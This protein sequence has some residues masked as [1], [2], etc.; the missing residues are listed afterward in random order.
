M[1]EDEQAAVGGVAGEVD[2][3][4]DLIVADLIGEG[5]VVE[6]DCVLPMMREG[7]EAL[8]DCVGVESVGIAEGFDAI[9]IVMGEEVLDEVADGMGAEIGGDV[10]DAEGA[11]GGE[12]ARGVWVFSRPRYS[13][14]GLGRGLRY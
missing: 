2:E 10:A 8:G 7:F 3:D 5:V 13:G 1:R 4:V 6:G 9:G 12:I 14:G 11:R